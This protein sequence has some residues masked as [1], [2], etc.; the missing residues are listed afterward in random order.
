MNELG[1]KLKMMLR[2]RFVIVIVKRL[3]LKTKEVMALKYFV[4]K[5]R[6]IAQMSISHLF[7]VS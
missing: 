6:N 2:L 4:K 7:R 1:L 3:V 5:I